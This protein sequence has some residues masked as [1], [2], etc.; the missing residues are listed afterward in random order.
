MEM[1]TITPLHLLVQGAAGN[2]RTWLH[3]LFIKGFSTHYF[4]ASRMFLPAA[5]TRSSSIP[6]SFSNRAYPHC[7][8]PILVIYPGIAVPKPGATHPPHVLHFYLFSLVPHTWRVAS[9]QMT[10]CW[11]GHLA[12]ITS[13]GSTFDF[14]LFHLLCPPQ[15]FLP[16]CSPWVNFTSQLPVKRTS[17]FPFLPGKRNNQRAWNGKFIDV[18]FGFKAALWPLIIPLVERELQSLEGVVLSGLRSVFRA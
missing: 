6:A 3:Y 10:G 12:L 5:S 18:G 15:S 1:K 2:P 13:P 8:G 4:I 7:A 16:D 17:D 14:C 9:R 11:H